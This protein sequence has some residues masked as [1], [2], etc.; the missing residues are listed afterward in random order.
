MSDRRVI[1]VSTLVRYLKG[2][3]EGNPVLHG[4]LVEGEI[5]NLR[6]PYSG[7]WY[8]SL[9]DDRAAV[10]CVMFASANRNVRFEVHNG[11]KV[12]V[13]GDVT[14]YESEGRMQI[15]A[16]GMQPSGIGALFLQLEQLKKK[17]HAE[18]LFAEE[19][20]KPL[21]RY[22]MD[23]AVVTGNQTAARSDVL[24]TLRKRWPAAAVH[25]YTVPVQG[26]SAAPQIVQALRTADEGSHDVILLVR[27]GGSIE[28]LWCFNDESL[29][30][31]I[32][33][34]RTPV[35]TG[36]GHETDTTLVD[37]TS[38]FRAN[39]PTG[40]AEAAT[41]DVREVRVLLKQN[42]AR[43]LQAVRHSLH[44][45]RTLLEQYASAPAL[46]TP[47]MLFREQ[48]MRLDYIREKLSQ[49]VR[50]AEKKRIAWQT[51][52]YR[53]TKTTLQRS[54]EIRTVLQ[55]QESHLIS[56]AQLLIRTQ[57]NRTELAALGLK[58]AAL[59]IAE[60]RRTALEKEMRLLDAYSPLKVLD[61]GYSI[62]THE[63]RAV[64]RSGE[65]NS[66]DLISIRFAEGT[67]EAEIICTVEQEEGNG[68]DKKEN[69]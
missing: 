15:I 34:M 27:G 26:A 25:E 28:D 7:H 18:G 6:Q 64:R 49:A 37:Y 10:P 63:G 35:I 50:S 9:K 51:L 60:R 58:N 59:R 56:S 21:P 32:Y 66:G 1:P 38:D 19:H 16:A 4:V 45:K 55:N 5:S 3:L 41:P 65:L 13:R 57:K 54:A 17:L 2:Q 44:R 47:Q 67:A 23:I 52:H 20:K 36:V 31:T 62:V 8:F 42:E 53:L 43:I 39:T 22:P 11:D 29:A 40:A 33:E 46:R 30:R 12:I 69:V 24:I 48:E 14:V 61:R 68:T